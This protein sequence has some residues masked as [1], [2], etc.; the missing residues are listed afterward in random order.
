MGD[1]QKDYKGGQDNRVKGDLL[2]PAAFEKMKQEIKE[3][4]R[5]LIP[6]KSN[7]YRIANNRFFKSKSVTEYEKKFFMQCRSRN[8][9]I[10]GYF[11]IDVKAYYP[12]ERSDLDGAFKL[13]MDCLQQCKVVKNDNRCIKIV[14]EKFVDKVDPRIELTIKEI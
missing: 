2:N 11:E 4:I 7:S 8:K 14:A 6:S 1:S 9:M 10:A 3:V 12:N 13:T 5:G